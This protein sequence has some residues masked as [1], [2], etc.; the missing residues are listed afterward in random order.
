M[1]TDPFEIYVGQSARVD[2]AYNPSSVLSSH[3]NYSRSKD[4]TYINWPGGAQPSTYCTFVGKASTGEN[5]TTIT[6]T[7]SDAALE[8]LVYVK[9]LPLPL[10]HFVDLVHG[11]PFAD[12]AATIVENALS[13]TKNTP[14]SDDWTT[15]NANPCEENHLH[16]VGWIREYRH[17]NAT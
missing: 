12:V 8:Q 1:T 16:L 2:V 17:R 7:H 15:P 4:D 11:K 3:K 13:A 5:T 6:L 9:V 10:T 14:T